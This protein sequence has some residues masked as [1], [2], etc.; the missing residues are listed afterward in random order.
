MHDLF[1]VLGIPRNAPISEFR[2]AC[3]RRVGR[4]H[5]DFLA[6]G[7]GRRPAA[8]VDAAPMTMARADLRDAAVDFVDVATLLD[9]IQAGF[10]TREA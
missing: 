9:R 5:P 2:R 7:G 6:G 1:H 4:T 10:F 3:A 8:S